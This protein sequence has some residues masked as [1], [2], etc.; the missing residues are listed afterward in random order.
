MA[1]KEK[2]VMY[3]CQRCDWI[4]PE[5]QGLDPHCIECG[6]SLEFWIATGDE[7][8]E[9]AAEIMKECEKTGL[10]VPLWLKPYVKEGVGNGIEKAEGS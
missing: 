5:C 4:A 8:G 3:F 7:P 1:E 2:I 10:P 6:R 9:A